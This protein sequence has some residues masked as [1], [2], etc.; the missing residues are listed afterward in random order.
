MNRFTF[1]AI[2][3]LILVGLGM[4]NMGLP[5]AFINAPSIG[6]V[7][8]GAFALTLMSFSIKEI[9]TAF[10]DAFKDAGS[11]ENPT[12]SLYLWKCILRNILMAGVTGNLLGSV[13][14]LAKLDDPKALG[15]ATG[16]ALLTTLY[17]AVFAAIG[18]VPAIYSIRRRLPNLS[19]TFGENVHERA[20][21]AQRVLGYLLY[22]G[23]VF[24]TMGKEILSFVDFASMLIVLGGTFAIGLTAL[25][26][27]GRNVESKLHACQLA[28]VAFLITAFIGGVVGFIEMVRTFSEPSQIGPGMAIVM[29]S[30]FLG[31]LGASLISFPMEDRCAKTL[32]EYAP[33]SFSQAVW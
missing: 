26:G 5:S 6:F 9:R 22:V 2:L 23:I 30:P 25:G 11:A 17:A 13:L 7:L 33:F 20:Y 3:F 8:I 18:P 28:S 19:E 31:M 1:S 21:L 27:N 32:G 15:P 12:A 29:L 10:S 14:M 24:G 4:G 16:I